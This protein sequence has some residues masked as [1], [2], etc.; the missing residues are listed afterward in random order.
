MLHGDLTAANV[1]HA[2]GG[3]GL[4]AVDPAPCWGDPAFD[5]VDLILWKA[6][7]LATCAARA[8]ELGRL[9]GFPADTALRWCA[10]L[11]AMTALEL[12]EA[13]APGAPASPQL[14]MLLELA[15]SF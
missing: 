6:Y 13:A 15:S 8:G 4:V 14:D 11:A 5:T 3:R 9:L 7:D 2:G 10:A 1:L 12:A